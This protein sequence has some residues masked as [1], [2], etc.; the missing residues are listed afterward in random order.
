M[1]IR[2]QCSWAHSDK[3]AQATEKAIGLIKSGIAR[4]RYSQA[5]EPVNIPAENVVVVVGAGIAGMRAAIELAD[6][7]SYVY[8]L[9]REYFIGGR[10]AQWNE[11]FTTN[12]T[13]RAV[14]TKLYKK[15]M[16][17]D[18]I[19]LFTGAE[20]ISSKGSVGNF[21]IE[22]N[23]KARHIKPDC[24]LDWEKFQKAVAV[25]PVEFDD[26]FN[27]GLTKQKAI[28]KNYPGEF[29]GISAID[30]EHCTRCGKCTNICDYID[31][32]QTDKI[33]HL[34]AGAYL[35]ATGFD[36]YEP[37]TGEFGYH[38]ISNVVTLQQLKR[39]YEIND[40]ELIHNGKPAHNVA[41][42][43]CVGS[44]Q[45][46]GEN[47][48]CSRYCCTSAIHTAILL[49]EKYHNITNVHFNRGIRTYGKQ[50][51]LYR[52]ASAQGDVFLQSFE[53]EPPV[54]ES[55]NGKA[56][57]RIKDFLTMGK[58]LEYEADLVV[59]VTGMV[60]RKNDTT[61]NILKVPVG[62]D[63]FYNEIHPKLRPVET[64]IDGVFISGS[65]QGPKNIT[66]SVNSALSAAAKAD[67]LVSKGSIELEPTMAKVDRELCKWCDTCSDA[68]PYDAI[69][70]INHNGKDI[71]SVNQANC[72]G[73][74]M[75]L[76][77]CPEN[78]LQLTGY[79]D[80]QIERMIEAVA[81]RFGDSSSKRN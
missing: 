59:L 81:S 65:C 15:V 1:N 56:V 33:V 2:E 13:A 28:Y 79:T 43:Y 53:D 5:L 30:T 52:K 16:S 57:V 29:P 66:E 80:L 39:L 78:A 67:S 54:V 51:I 3:P 34:R 12:E 26:P 46:D 44:R 27:F 74:G 7:G 75:C 48:Y 20:I 70:K 69:V 38:E 55:H 21:E 40:K 8:L 37:G 50:E 76:P 31:L 58:E 18:R 42:I 19:T 49:K 73:C 63:K 25:C 36:P 35:L 60:P 9:E 6:M 22:V 32:E 77:V 68:C 47:K 72:K 41:Y 10:S 4:A 17:Y 45:I 14:I 62:R 61:K 64:V 11:L 71:A 24:K 23:I